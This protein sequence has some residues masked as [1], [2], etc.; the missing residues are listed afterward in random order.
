MGIGDLLMRSSMGVIYLW[1]KFLFIIIYWDLSQIKV[2][3][4]LVLFLNYLRHNDRFKEDNLRIGAISF[5]Q[6]KISRKVIQNIFDQEDNPNDLLETRRNLL[7]R[8]Y[9]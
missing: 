9:I 5:F 1:R 2:L 4:M 3:F 7:L 8:F 6:Q